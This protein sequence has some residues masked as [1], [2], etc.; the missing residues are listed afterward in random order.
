MFPLCRYFA[1]RFPRLLLVAYGFALKHLADDPTMSQ[2]FLPA[3]RTYNFL[4]DPT[5][6]LDARATA[7]RAAAAS[8]AAVGMSAI[9][10]RLFDKFH[11]Y[12]FWCGSHGCTI[13]S[14]ISLGN[15]AAARLKCINL[16]TDSSRPMCI[17]V[18]GSSPISLDVP[19]LNLY[20]LLFRFP[21]FITSP[22]EERFFRDIRY[23][24]GGGSFHLIGPWAGQM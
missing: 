18:Q 8:A 3:A 24:K 14:R 11:Y 12:R 13:A 19:L 5:A 2:Y 17:D 20:P 23:I 7:N 22:L 6:R 16:S 10:V 9:A 21:S 4:A 1:S 15:T